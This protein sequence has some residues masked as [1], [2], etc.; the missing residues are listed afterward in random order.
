MSKITIDG[1][2][3]SGT[4]CFICTQDGNSGR[5]RVKTVTPACRELY[6]V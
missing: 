1:F 2:T 4:R 6:C 3:R 5:Q